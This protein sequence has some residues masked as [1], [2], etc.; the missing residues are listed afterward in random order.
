MTPFHHL[1]AAAAN[2][3]VRRQGLHLL[4]FEDDA[5]LGD[6]ATLRPKQVRDRLE[7]R[8]LA[9]AVRTKK[10]CDTA[11]RNGERHAF[12]NEDHVIVD[13]LNI[14]DRKDQLVLRADRFRTGCRHLKIPQS[15]ARPKPGLISVITAY[16]RRSSAK[17]DWRQ[18]ILRKLFPPSDR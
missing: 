13:Y 15:V 4:A 16:S 1:D 9:R 18:R 12:E 7:R 5:A 2:Q 17:A 11:A 8:R 14:V 6:V 10:C 3:F